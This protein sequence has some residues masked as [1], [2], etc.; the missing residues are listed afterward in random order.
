[1]NAPRV[2]CWAVSELRGLIREYLLEILQA[3]DRPLAYVDEPPA[4][5]MM[6]GVNGAGRPPR[7]AN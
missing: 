7:S 3:N 6:V 5:I 4:V 2:I 1:M